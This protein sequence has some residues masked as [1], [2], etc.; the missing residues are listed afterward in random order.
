M[1]EEAA[2]AAP[3]HLDIIPSPV[4]RR[5]AQRIALH[6]SSEFAG[7]LDA[8]Q[9]VRELLLLASA[10]EAPDAEPDLLGDGDVLV[11]RRLLD[12]LRSQVLDDWE[13]ATELPAVGEVL[14]LLQGFERV[15]ARLEPRWSELFA[16]RLLGPDALELVV[17][18]A[19]DLRSPLTSILF[20]SETL[21]R[22]QS[23][24]ITDVQRRQLGIIYSAALGLISMAS[25]MIELAR[26]GDRLVETERAPFSVAEILESTRDIVQPMAEEKGLS[27]RLLTATADQRLGYPV[28]LSRVLL[29]L[30]SNALKFTDEGFVELTARSTEVTRVELSVRDTGEGLDPEM[31]QTLFQPFHRAPG[32]TGYA[33][34]GSGLGLAI[35]RKLVETMGGELRYESRRGWGTR[36]YFELDLPLASLL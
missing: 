11:R 12:L 35:S 7:E 15:R 4:L 13:H 31:A 3:H 20:L 29:N 26:G 30:T 1:A 32:R 36:F 28:A 2:S 21:R 19:H 5:A 25:D 18:V 22:G 24:D 14:S 10:V 9:V 16:S 17:E 33:F 23:G 34:S 8:A 6:R 27:I